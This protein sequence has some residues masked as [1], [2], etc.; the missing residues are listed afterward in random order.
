MAISSSGIGSGLDVDSIVTRLMQVEQQP[1]VALA[2]REAQ[3]TSQL[4]T[5]GTIK[6]ALSSFQTAASAL[7][8]A[9]SSTA[10]KLSS[11]DSTSVS[12]SAGSTSVAGTYNVTVTQLAQAQRLVAAGQTS[13]G[14]KIGDGTPT[15]LAFSFGSITGGT[16]DVNSGTY[17]GATF[18]ADPARTAV[19]VQIGS[20]NNTLEGIRDAINAANAGVTAAIV[21]DGSAAPYR[22]TITS[23][24]TGAGN[25]LKIGVTG[26]AD[27][28]TLLASDPGG[29]Q[30]LRQTQTALDAQLSISG[31]AISRPTNNI[32]DAIQGVTLKL[33]K[34]TTDVTVSV[35]RDST[36]ISSALKS[37][38]DSYN[39]TNRAI[40]SATALKALLQGDTATVSIL[41][42]LRSALGVIL[43]NS[44]GS[45]NS[46]SQLG[47]SFQKDGSL[48]FDSTK[49]QGAIDADPAS[50]LAA[51]TFFGSSLST[52]ADRLAGSGGVLQARTDG[53]NR[54]IADL[55][56]RSDAMSQRLDGVEKRYR[57]QFTALDVL[58]SNMQQTSNFL[59]Q[60]LANLPKTSS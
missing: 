6:G 3:F 14:A 49:A 23:N 19:Q 36:N 52:L 13:L 50:V 40:K 15:T 22:L 46:L 48:T 5:L 10:Y 9:G 35:A 7:K 1:L 56:R 8:T 24:A 44:G 42:R 34:L 30:N 28:T 21:N 57:A 25:S 54:S 39:D 12:G 18:T 17:S 31:I 41:S 20:S 32:A 29:T 37:I 33:S 11:S 58:M 59:T 60:Q 55:T 27:I 38:V 16:L 47:V 26:S 45:I 2:Q 4:S 43:N 51:A 53:I